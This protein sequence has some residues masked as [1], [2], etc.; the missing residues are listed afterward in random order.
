MRKGVKSGLSDLS[1]FL[2][3]PKQRN[4]I[5]RD[6][7]RALSGRRGTQKGESEKEREGKRY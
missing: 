4:S 1:L 5:P 6:P 2:K 7:D 3:N